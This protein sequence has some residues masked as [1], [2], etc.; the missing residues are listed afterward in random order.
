MPEMVSC[1][2]RVCVLYTLLDVQ[3]FTWEIQSIG[4]RMKKEKTSS[5]KEYK[6]MLLLKS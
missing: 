4:A 5:A 6:R 2:V 1:C 3:V